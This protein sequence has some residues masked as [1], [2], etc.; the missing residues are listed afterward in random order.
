LGPELRLHRDPIFAPAQAGPAS[1]GHAG[2]SGCLVW[3][4][5]DAGVAWAILGTRH[6]AGWWGAPLFGELGAAVLATAM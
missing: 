2:S 3:A 5:P 1:F 4:D 6:M